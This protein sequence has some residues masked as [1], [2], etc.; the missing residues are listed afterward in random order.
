MTTLEDG[1]KIMDDVFL[2]A[3]GLRKGGEFIKYKE[4]TILAPY[5]PA[6]ENQHDERVLLVK[7]EV[8]SLGKEDFS[9]Q[10]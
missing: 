6:I 1:K 5:Y 7:N 3:D 2:V 8:S 10:Q 4:I 9:K